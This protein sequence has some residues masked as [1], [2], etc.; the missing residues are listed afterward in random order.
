[1]KSSPH[2]VPRILVR[3]IR[4]IVYPIQTELFTRRLEPRLQV[5][6]T[7]VSREVKKETPTFGKETKGRSTESV[8][9]SLEAAKV[10][11]IPSRVLER[12]CRITIVST[13]EL[14]QLDSFPSQTHRNDHTWSSR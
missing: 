11:D 7:A 14:Q 13:C 10:P 3:L 6:S 9:D 2:N 5:V 1:M 12:C 8:G 4:S